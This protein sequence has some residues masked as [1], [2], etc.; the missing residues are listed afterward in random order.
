MQA[1]PATWRLLLAARWAGSPQLTVLCGG[2]ALPRELAQQ[3]LARAK[4]VWNLYGPTETTIWS[5]LEHVEAGEGPVPIG[6]AIAN[7]QLYVLDRHLH[8]VPIGVPGELYI[9]GAGI[10]RGY[11]NRPDLTAEQFVADPFNATATARLYKTGDLVR[12]RA[13]GRLEFWG[14]L[15]QQVKLRG[16]RVE[17]GE[18]EAVLSQHAEVNQAVV[19]ARQESPGN[20]RLVAYVV[21][22]PDGALTLSDLRQFLHMKLPD[23]MVPAVCTFLDALPLT[24]NGKVDRRSLPVPAPSALAEGFV[25]PCTAA[26][27]LLAGIWAQVLGL[28]QVGRHDNFFELGGDSILSMQIIAKANLAGLRFTPRQIFQH[29]TLAELAAV[30]DMT[31]AMPALQGSIT[32]QPPVTEGNTCA[33]FP[34][35]QLGEGQ[36][37]QAFGEIAFEGE[38]T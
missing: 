11:V 22:H 29:Q 32:G 28:E 1:T 5:A 8:P 37:E 35:A 12:T 18:I 38:D 16:F 20:T 31:P 30:A 7:T 21:P 4:A 36:L 6:R 9:G 10:A 33:D 3:L 26:E 23:Y 15:D 24:P 13:D 2:E 17:L 19:L 14:R 27:V 25:A 34:L